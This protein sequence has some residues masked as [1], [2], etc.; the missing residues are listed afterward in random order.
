MAATALATGGVVIVTLIL[1]F[2]DNLMRFYFKPR[3]PFQITEPPQ[4]PDYRSRA[5][6]VLWPDAPSTAPK[7]IQT[8]TVPTLREA[9]A[10][11]RADVFYVHSTTYYASKSWNAPID[12]QQSAAETRLIAAPNE[13]GPFLDIGRVFAP[14][15]RQATLATQ[16][17]HKYDAMAARATAYS[18]VRAAFKVFLEANNEERPIFLVGYEQGAL[19]TMGL[20]KEFFDGEDN[21][22]R[23]RLATAYLI[24]Q[25]APKKLFDE[26]T[27]A[28]PVC[29]N[30]KAVR[31]VVAFT[32]FEE[33]FG[34][35]ISRARNRS[36][37]WT[38]DI[39]QE[40]AEFEPLVCVNPLNWRQDAG[41]V[42]A[43][44]HHGAASAT[45]LGPNA[46]APVVSNAIGAACVDGVLITDKPRQ[47][48]MRRSPWFGEKWKARP[49]NLFY[50][51]LADNAA[52]RRAALAV[53]LEEEARF[54]KPIGQNID[55]G[56]APIHKVPK[57]TR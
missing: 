16:F 13:A 15:Y 9:G 34:S 4:Q 40:S 48:Y 55:I 30:Q 27:P 37:L 31:C 36:I 39:V 25:S 32:D 35:E 24:G 28:L 8:S 7:T 51:D 57:T 17:T 26:M 23:R 45:G 33:R 5:A 18:D 44:R 41:P 50:Q 11:A 10:G 19:H 47:P 56:A 46:P 49:Y 21:Q 54:L 3:T 6:W 38:D 42:S 20:L 52:L 1:L 29:A 53:Q 2:Q 14:S 12:D 22:L 43:K